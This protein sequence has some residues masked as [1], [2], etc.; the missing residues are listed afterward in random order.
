MITKVKW[1]NHE[2]LGNLELNFT[3]NDGA[4]YSTIVLAGENGNRYNSGIATLDPREI[5]SVEIIDVVKARYLKDG[6][7]KILN[8]KLKMIFT[9]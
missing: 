7:Q 9:Q 1:N 2:I 4:P 5:E 8:I 3:K 6:Y